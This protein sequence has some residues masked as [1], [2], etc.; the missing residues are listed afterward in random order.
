MKGV[1][2]DVDGVIVDV[3]ESYHLAIKMTAE[4]FLGHEVDLD[5]VRAIKFGKGINNDWIATREV[6]KYFGKEIEIEEIISVF[7]RIYRQVRDKEKLIL[8][9][10]FFSYLKAQNIPLGILTGRP[11][12]DLEYTF[13]RFGLFE[14]FDFILDD[15][16]ISV[17]ELKKPHP[18]ALHLCIE[19]MNL[20]ACAYVGDSKADW[21]MVNS[22]RKMYEKS[23]KYVHFGQN[24]KVDGVITV[25][26]PDELAL[27]LQEVLKHL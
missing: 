21:E 15:D 6:I 18:F 19:S 9:G 20:S 17:E 25:N 1:I 10:K 12:E 23:V 4:A 2:F 13:K 14:Y 22:Y 24:V 26:A 8:D 7:N 16:Q 11:K 3:K 5:T 27:T